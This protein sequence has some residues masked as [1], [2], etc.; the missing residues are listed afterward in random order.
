MVFPKLSK[1]TKLG[2]KTHSKLHIGFVPLAAAKLFVQ[3]HV[4]APLAVLQCLNRAG[5]KADPVQNLGKYHLAY[6]WPLICEM[7]RKKEF[8]KELVF[9]F[10]MGDSLS[11]IHPVCC[12]VLKEAVG[13]SFC[14]WGT[15]VLK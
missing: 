13:I 8:L 11:F 5:S 10:S 14:V 9:G 12:P 6:V 3:R 7:R 2:K 15:V 1:S 4:T